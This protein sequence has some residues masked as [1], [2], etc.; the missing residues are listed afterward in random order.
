MKA[1]E[2]AVFG[3]KRTIPEGMIKDWPPVDDSDKDLVL[4]SLTGGKHAFGRAQL[5]KIGS[6]IAKNSRSRCVERPRRPS[7]SR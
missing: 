6:V 2:L 7:R 1:K 5:A 4:K 3:G